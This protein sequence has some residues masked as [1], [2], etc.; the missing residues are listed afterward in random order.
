MV[1]LRG[2]PREY[3]AILVEAAVWPNSRVATQRMALRRV[4][5]RLQRMATRLRSTREAAVAVLT[6]VLA[7]RPG[8]SS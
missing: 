3:R 5:S 1:G 8:G 2:L 7:E 4:A 6:I